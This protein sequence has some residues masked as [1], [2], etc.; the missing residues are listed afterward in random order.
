MSTPEDDDAPNYWGFKPSH[1]PPMRWIFKHKPEFV[2][3]KDGNTYVKIHPDD[4]PLLVDDCEYTT[5][6]PT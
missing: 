1:F 2:T 4:V 3:G 6:D 5:E